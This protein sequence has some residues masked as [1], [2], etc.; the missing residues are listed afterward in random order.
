MA[1]LIRVD[2]TEQQLI[3]STGVSFSLAE[4]QDLVGG[5]IEILELPSGRLLVLDEEGK[6]AGKPINPRATWLGAVAQIAHSEV[7]VGDVLVCT[8]TELNGLRA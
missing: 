6:L 4:L 3:P 5:Y 2:G 7:I 8:A 1:Q